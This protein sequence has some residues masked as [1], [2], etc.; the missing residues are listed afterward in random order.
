MI[1]FKNI[2]KEMYHFATNDNVNHLLNKII[3][4]DDI[5]KE[6]LK[7][8]ELFF[9]F[10]STYAVYRLMRMLGAYD[11]VVLSNIVMFIGQIFSNKLNTLGMFFVFVLTIFS[12]EMN[13][14]L[15][16]MHWSV[17]KEVSFYWMNVV[18]Y[19]NYE[20]W[21]YDVKYLKKERNAWGMLFLLFSGL[22]LFSKVNLII[23]IVLIVPTLLNYISFLMK[24]DEF[25]KGREEIFNYIQNLYNDILEGKAEAI[26]EFVDSLD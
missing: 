25:Y 20:Q 8:P 23:K 4:K 2:R 3:H 11:F 14:L 12:I 19:K 6:M 26:N 15:R 10:F 22:V 17:A 24:F 9:D 5:K 1:N 16:K 13:R 21:S 18:E 7:S